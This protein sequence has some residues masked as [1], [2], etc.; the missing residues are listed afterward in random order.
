VQTLLLKKQGGTTAV[1]EEDA[2][3][4]VRAGIKLALWA[5]GWQRS[6]AALKL[7]AQ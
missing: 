7:L 1:V 4:A 2:A 5:R 6:L 3:C